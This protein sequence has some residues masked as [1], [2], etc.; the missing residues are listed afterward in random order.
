MAQVVEN[1]PS[2]SEALISN[3]ST[4]KGGKKKKKLDVKLILVKI[5]SV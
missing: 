1:Q 3:P 2:N 4:T 5:P